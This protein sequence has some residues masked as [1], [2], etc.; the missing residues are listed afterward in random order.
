[1]NKVQCQ[2]GAVYLVLP[3]VASEGGEAGAE[4][5]QPAP[6]GYRVRSRCYNDVTMMLQ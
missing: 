2:Q 1:M 5:V 6:A 4:L 3:V